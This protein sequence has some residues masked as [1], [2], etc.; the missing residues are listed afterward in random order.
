MYLE[1][2]CCDVCGKE[3]FR[4]ETSVAGSKVTLAEPRKVVVYRVREWRRDLVFC[5]ADACLAAA[6]RVEA[7]VIAWWNG[8]GSEEAVEKMA[9]GAADAEGRSQN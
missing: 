5:K 2:V 4:S 3:I 7:R 1:T 6:S 9:P 8:G